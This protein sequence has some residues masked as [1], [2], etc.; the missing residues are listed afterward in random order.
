MKK[1]KFSDSKDTSSG[2]G[3]VHEDIGD[4]DDDNNDDDGN[5]DDGEEHEDEDECTSRRPGRLR[6]SRPSGARS[7]RP[8]RDGVGGGGAPARGQLLYNLYTVAAEVLLHIP[9]AAR[10]WW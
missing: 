1:R 8:T 9:H 2:D 6:P 10:R 5:G 3:G 7:T 4:D